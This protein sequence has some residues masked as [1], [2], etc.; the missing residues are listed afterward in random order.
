MLERRPGSP[1]HCQCT[2]EKTGG[3]GGEVGQCETDQTMDVRNAL[4]LPA[5]EKRSGG[6]VEEGV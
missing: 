1:A 2:E 4:L 6:G 5:R 3:D